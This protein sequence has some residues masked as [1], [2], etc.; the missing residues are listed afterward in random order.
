MG[1][2]YCCHHRLE[3]YTTGGDKGQAPPLQK[4]GY[5]FSEQEDKDMKH[6]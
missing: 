2:V 5:K 1:Q 6:P 4:I 3:A